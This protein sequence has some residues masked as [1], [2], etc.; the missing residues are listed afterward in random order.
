MGAVMMAEHPE[1]RWTHPQCL[2]CWSEMNLNRDPVRVI[3]AEL[4]KC[5]RCGLLTSAGI[6]VR[7]D[8]KSAG[9]TMCPMR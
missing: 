4:E 8:A 2:A 3:G 5:C 1:G 9:W 7:A 6:Y